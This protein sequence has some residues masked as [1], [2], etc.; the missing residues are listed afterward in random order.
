MQ[1]KKEVMEGRGL[2]KE[3]MEERE[4]RKE[5]SYGSKEVME[6]WKDERKV[7]VEGR[8]GTIKRKEGRKEGN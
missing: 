4:L 3:V 8:R 5:G 7:V 1:G 6:G 2:W